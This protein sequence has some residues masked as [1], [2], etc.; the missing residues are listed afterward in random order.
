MPNYCEN[1]LLLQ[2]PEED[3]AA[4]L[5][6]VGT[7]RENPV[8]DF[9]VIIPYPEPFA[10]MD[11]DYPDYFSERSDPAEYGRKMEAYRAKWGTGAD[12]YNG[13]GYD[14]CCSNWGT[15]SLGFDIARR[16]YMGRTILTF[17]TAWSPPSK[18]LLSAVAKQ[19]PAMDFHLEYFERGLGFCGGFSI[20]SEESWCEDRKWEPGL[21]SDQWS[22]SDYN[23]R[24]GG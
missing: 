10:S 5:E 2:G 3:I 8:F 12:G 24:R 17:R 18:S 21:I 6:H 16:D 4:L 20:R 19:F 7:L 9:G 11:K 13:G 1:D 23:G 14:W 22:S 15:K